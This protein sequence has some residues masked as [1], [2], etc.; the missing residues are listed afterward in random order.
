MLLC[1]D[2]SQSLLLSEKNGVFL[3]KTPF[4]LIYDC[5]FDCLYKKVIVI[6]YVRVQ[7][8]TIA[9]RLLTYPYFAV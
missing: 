5:F 2:T 9:P 3:N 6:F 4:F 7:Y 1:I 8:L